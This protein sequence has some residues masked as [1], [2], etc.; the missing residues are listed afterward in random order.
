MS[1]C[2]PA[3]SACQPPS[4]LRARGRRPPIRRGA[5]SPAR[6]SSPWPLSERRSPAPGCRLSEQASAQQIGAQT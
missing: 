3:D 5:L 2:G 4:L 6:C 1:L